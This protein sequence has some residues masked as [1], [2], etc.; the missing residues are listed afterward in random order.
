MH[1]FK[2]PNISYGNTDNI[3]AIQAFANHRVHCAIY[4][5]WK[6]HNIYFTDVVKARNILKKKR[7][8]SLFILSLVILNGQISFNIISK[9]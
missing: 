2:I 3:T 1:F 9:R 7:N 8:I 6:I 4:R 5:F